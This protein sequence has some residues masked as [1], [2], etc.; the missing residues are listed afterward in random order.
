MVTRMIIPIQIWMSTG[1]NEEA[2]MFFDKYSQVPEQYLKIK[3]LLNENFIPRRL[4]FFDNLELDDQT[5]NVYI[6]EYPETIEG[7]I[8]SFVDR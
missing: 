7:I 5:Q 4:Q 3:K 6:K 2:A 8:Q 1:N